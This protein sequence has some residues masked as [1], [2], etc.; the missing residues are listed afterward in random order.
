MRI[1]RDSGK[2]DYILE[3]TPLPR[4]AQLPGLS[5]PIAMLVKVTDPAASQH[6][7]ASLLRELYRLTEA[8]CRLVQAL[9]QGLTLKEA[10]TGFKVSENTVRSQLSAVFRKTGV[11]RQEELIRL[12]HGLGAG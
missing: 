3:F 1:R 11:R 7:P 10:A 6:V 12:A 9:L 4:D 2:A 8:E 5:G